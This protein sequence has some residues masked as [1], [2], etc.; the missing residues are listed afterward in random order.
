MRSIILVELWQ[1][2]QWMRECGMQWVIVIKEQINKWKLQ[3][4][5]RGLI[6]VRTKRVYLYQDLDKSMMHWYYF[7]YDKIIFIQGLSDK[8]I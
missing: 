8:A 3:N 2:V 1:V 5:S 7:I 4:V 6:N